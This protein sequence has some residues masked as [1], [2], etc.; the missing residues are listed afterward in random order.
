MRRVEAIEVIRA[1]REELQLGKAG[2][3]CGSPPSD[4]AVSSV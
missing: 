3:S 2:S 1:V 4:R